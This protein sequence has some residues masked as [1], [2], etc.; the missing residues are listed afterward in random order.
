MPVWVVFRD[1]V[2]V[3]IERPGQGTRTAAARGRP[4]A[5]RLGSMTRLRSARTLR[6]LTTAQEI[7]TEM[8]AVKGEAHGDKLAMA[9]NGDRPRV[10]GGV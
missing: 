3:A 7:A 9:D 10:I 8:V 6:K 4:K 2:A 5:M 1:K